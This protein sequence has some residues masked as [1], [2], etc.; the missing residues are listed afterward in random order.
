MEVE[1]QLLRICSACI[2]HGSF[3]DPNR[4]FTFEK[5]FEVGILPEYGNSSSVILWEAI[6]HS[7]TTSLEITTKYI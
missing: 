6:P 5:P 3:K 7:H 4:V 1:A 2:F